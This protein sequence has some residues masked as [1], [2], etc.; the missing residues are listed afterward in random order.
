M[1][2]R[3]GYFEIAL[4]ATA[5]IAPLVLSAYH[6]TIASYVMMFA[7]VCMGLVLMTGI[8]GMVSFG[9]AAFVG[10]GAYATGYLTSTFG[11]SAWTGLAAAVT[12]SGLVAVTIGSILVRMSGHYLALATLC[13][14]I[15][16]YFLVGNTEAFGLFN[17]ISG[18]PPVSIAGF[19]LRSE[20]AGYFL[21]LIV[22]AVVVL[23]TRRILASRVGR[24]LRS[25]RAGAVIAESFGADA[26][27]H[28]LIA[29]VAAAILAALSGWLYAHVQRFVNPT[30]FGVHASIEYLFMTVIGGSGQVM[31]ALLGAGLVTLLKHELQ[32]LL[33]PF[34]GMTTRLEMLVFAALMLYILYRAPRGILPLLQAWM[35]KTASS[36]PKIAPVSLTDKRPAVVKVTP[37]LAAEGLQRSF[38]GLIA[39]QDVSLEVRSREILGLLGPNG[40]GKS[41]VFNLISGTLAR[42]AG[43]VTFLGEE[44]SEVTARDMCRRGMSRTFQHVKL[45]PD[46]SLIENVAIGATRLGHCGLLSASLRLDREEEK[47]L[48]GWSMH[49]LDRV[50]LGEKAWEPAGALP[51]GHQRVLE[52]ARALAA[53]PIL[54]LLD[55]PAAGLRANEKAEL[56]ALLSGLRD[57]GLGVLLVEHDVDFVSRLA[58]RLMV[59]NFGRRIAYGEPAMVRADRGVQEAY[60][61]VAA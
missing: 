48:L 9:Q 3:P 14:C 45:V 31:G 49:L 38:G 27:R 16:F 52:I 33:R 1:S 34:F 37:I 11:F 28:R 25:L 47:K 55:E 12:V 60:L 18:I 20:R 41:T 7:I 51:L 53:D 46:M 2:G 13:F 32:E 44:L 57:D 43:R 54:L 35:P 36:Q 24:V 42:H 39:V 40:A 23:W 17:G 19:E 6:L 10:L 15:S 30:P 4:L 5:L 58:D 56:A 59:M 29:F 61:G 26:T 22:L 50:G 21:V 8:A